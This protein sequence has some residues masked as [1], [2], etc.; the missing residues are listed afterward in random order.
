MLEKS[1]ESLE[2]KLRDEITH[3]R[4]ILEEKVITIKEKYIDE[5]SYF[6]DKVKN[7]EE[8]HTDEISVLKEKHSQ[9]LQ[10][11]KL[12]HSNQL[13][14]IKE[15]KKLEGDLLNKS[16]LYSEKI[17]T[18]VEMLNKNTK[19]LQIIEDKVLHNYDAH[20]VS[21]EN[22]IQAKEKEIICKFIETLQFPFKF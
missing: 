22:S 4:E 19:T 18:S 9:M 21:R 14:H 10:E 1:N 13:E 20:T 6:K 8:E 3:I 17:D 7:M 12:D 11:L 16:T 2:A 5:I 15:M